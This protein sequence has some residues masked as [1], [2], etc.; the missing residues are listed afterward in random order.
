MKTLA[1]PMLGAAVL[2][3]AAVAAGVVWGGSQQAAGAG[4][5]VVTT[6]AID[7]D[8]K[9]GTGSFVND[10]HTV[11]TID[12]CIEVAAGGTVEFDVVV[13]AIPAGVGESDLAGYQFFMGF[14]STNLTF[15]GQLKVPGGSNPTPDGIHMIMRA[16]GSCSGVLGCHDTGEGVPEPPDSGSPP[17]P[18]VHDVLVADGSGSWVGNAANDPYGKAGGVL[19]RYTITVSGTAP[20][21]IYGIGLNSSFTYESNLS[22]SSAGKIWDLPGNGADDDSDGAV[23][24]DLMLDATAGHGLIAVDVSCSEGPPA[25]TGTPAPTASPTP[26]VS[27]PPTPGPQQT[28]LMLGWNNVCYLGATRP[29]EEAL[30]DIGEGVLAVYRLRAGQGYDR[31]LPGRP[32]ASTIVTLD[33]YEPLFILMANSAPWT[34]QGQASPP[35]AVSLSEGWNNV[36]YTGETKDAVSATTAIEG[37]F[38]VLYALGPDQSWQRFVPTRPDVSNL[39]QLVRLGP[40]LILVTQPGG[41]QWMFDP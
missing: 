11:G 3:V 29:I 38:A 30:A 33:S 4:N 16:S 20:A 23:D 37:K 5:S 25:P 27:P 21:G 34:Q 12:P 36:C 41:T 24:E 7:M 15:T 2:L 28:N 18:G 8:P 17:S 14:D 19:G 40:V 6:L 9:D 32:D 26:S 35:M 22:D 39:S 1:L 31:W 13:D 10:D